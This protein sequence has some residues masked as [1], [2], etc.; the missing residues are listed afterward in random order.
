MGHSRLSQYGIV[1]TREAFVFAGSS[2]PAVPGAAWNE[3]TRL[4]GT[5]F[6]SVK[7]PATKT[8]EPLTAIASTPR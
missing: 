3:A 2:A 7:L 8:V 1:C 5:P 6:A 4:R